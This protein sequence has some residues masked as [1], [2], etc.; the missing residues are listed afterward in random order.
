[1][2]ALT[3]N[4]IL[5]AGTAPSFVNASA[6][7]TV[8]IGN[9]RNTFVVYKNADGTNAK[10]VTVVV[11]GNGPYSEAYADAV[12]TVAP[13]DQVWIPIYKAADPGDGSNAA[14]ITVTGTGGATSV[15]VAA[16]RVDFN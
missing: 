7:D 6:S 12:Y 1:M 10:T 4:H 8:D 11:P 2:S 13:N 5:D 14:T 3:V 9:G 16:V 15:T